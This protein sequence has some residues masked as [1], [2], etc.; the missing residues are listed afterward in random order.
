MRQQIAWANLNK[1]YRQ[2]QQQGSFRQQRVVRT[3][4]RRTWVEEEIE[5]KA[6]E[7]R[8]RG[9]DPDWDVILNRTAASPLMIV[10]GYNIIHH[11]PRLK[12]HMT[13]GDPGRARQLL[14]DDL[15]NL[16]SI[17]GW[18]IECVFDGT[19]RSTMG[20]LGHGPG[21]GSTTIGNA[22]RGLDQ[23]TKKTVSKYGV[24]VVFTGVGIEADS[25]IE[26]RCARAK[27]VTDGEFTGSFILATD[28]VMIRIAGQSAGAL[29]MSANRFVDELKAVNRA[30]EYRVEA[31]VAKVNGHS[32][33]PSQLRGRANGAG[34][35]MPTRFGRQSILMEDKRK[36]RT[37]V[38]QAEEEYEID[39]SD[40]QVEEDENGIPWWAKV[41]DQPN[42]YK[43]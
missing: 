39:L 26:S 16:Q 2:Q 27:N 21:S 10:D 40:I 34:T 11:W 18:R 7:R 15:E 35:V 17:K 38:V 28:D 20:P 14:V 33:R 32:I 6:L 31:A 8:K 13:K 29:C 43:Q 25:Y 30:V 9:Q 36:N 24:R 4:Y 3:S 1:D 19:K 23:A 12:K 42:R 41:P 37:K 22:N 5:E